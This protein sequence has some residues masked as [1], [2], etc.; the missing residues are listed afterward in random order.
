MSNIEF[1]ELLNILT[2]ISEL[3]KE[4]FADILRSNKI[5]DK[6]LNTEDGNEPIIKDIILTDVDETSKVRFKSKCY[7]FFSG[8]LCIFIY[9]S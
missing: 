2:F 1:F 7:V 3:A 9:Y 6:T 4:E 8:K 5:V